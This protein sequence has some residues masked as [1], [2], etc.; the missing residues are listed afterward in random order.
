MDP[1][2]GIDS[3]VLDRRIFFDPDVY[4]AELSAIFGRCWLFL[5]HESQVSNPGDFVTTYMGE[6]PVLVTRSKTGEI[7]AFFNSC[8]HRGMRLCRA[9]AGNATTFMCSYHGWAYRNDGS[10]NTVPRQSVAYPADLNTTDWDLIRV[11]QIESYKGL[12]FATWDPKAPPLADYLGHM[13]HYL[14]IILDR[15]EGGTEFIG[16]TQKWTI[17]CNW[18]FLS[19]N[20]VGDSY[21][22]PTTHNSGMVAGF[23]SRP[24]ERLN[25]PGY[26]VYAG[27][28]HGMCF[29]REPLRT[30]LPAMK[31]YVDG[32]QAEAESR[33]GPVRSTVWPV[34]GA[35]FP[36]F[37][38]VVAGAFRTF[39]VWHPKG[40][41]KV[42]IWSWCIVDKAADP[43]FKNFIRLETLRGQSGPASTF[44]QDDGENF[45][46]CHACSRV[47]L[48]Q[49]PKFNYMLRLNSDRSDE[50]FPG[51]L[52]DMPSETNQLG[53]YQR[54][55]EMMDA[56]AA[57][58][59]KD[60]VYAI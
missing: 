36:N 13:A 37:G 55:H 2:N 19:D 49:D 24:S 50:N 51:R 59:R 21:H 41:D 27:N 58:A 18:K 43:A 22:T 6:V 10:L 12:V 33:L 4:R 29:F 1:K 3:G 9:D 35:V 11:A 57:L 7:N 17:Q 42:E 52:N 54:W 38:F 25:K 44:E 34:N 14:D 31:D 26:T 28:G 45:K 40:P 46:E 39:R 15:R 56:D 47:S 30:D 23:Y 48:P 16:G 5:A 60:T 32:H 8:R 53:F 20:H